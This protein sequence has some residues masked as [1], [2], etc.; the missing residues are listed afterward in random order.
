MK[1]NVRGWVKM[2]VY[3]DYSTEDTPNIDPELRHDHEQ[4]KAIARVWD[5]I[6][7]DDA[8][9]FEWEDSY[10]MFVPDVDPEVGSSD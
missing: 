8:L 1:R 9:E 3:M 7:D 5:A 2:I 4:D 10:I 6:K